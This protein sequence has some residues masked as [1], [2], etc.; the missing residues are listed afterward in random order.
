[1]CAARGTGEA[2][3]KN[4]TNC[5]HLCLLVRPT[6][7]Y[8]LCRSSGA[9]LLAIHSSAN[10]RTTCYG[11]PKLAR[12]AGELHG[13]VSILFLTSSLV[14]EGRGWRHPPERRN[15]LPSLTAPPTSA[16]LESPHRFMTGPFSPP[17]SYR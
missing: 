1:M 9:S 8:M 11:Q 10:V 7:N 15:R 17:I 6:S 2:I 3:N 12:K 16:P 14:R 5:N 4:I 13:A